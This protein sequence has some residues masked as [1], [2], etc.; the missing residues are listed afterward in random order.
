ME[1]SHPTNEPTLSSQPIFQGR[2]VG[3][4]VDTVRLPDGKTGQ[5]EVV[6]HGDA[7]VVVPLDGEGRVLMVRQYRKPI[8]LHLLEL[9]AGG[10]DGNETPEAGALREMQEETGFLPGRLVPLGGFYAAPG[11]CQEY[12]HLFLA[13]DLRPSKLAHDDDEHLVLEKLSLAEAL[14]LVESGG[15]RDAKSVA[16]LLRAERYLLRAQAPDGGS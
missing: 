9:P 10:L 16:G 1:P 2:V 12:L 13:S 3:L 14:A 7:V 5:R 4:R 11:Y 15:I 6:E 8:E